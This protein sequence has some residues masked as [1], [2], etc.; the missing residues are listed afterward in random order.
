MPLFR[1]PDLCRGSRGGLVLG[2]I[3]QTSYGLRH[4]ECRSPAGRM[5]DGGVYAALCPGGVIEPPVTADCFGRK[6]SWGCQP[7][8]VIPQPSGIMFPPPTDVY[9]MIS[10]EA[11]KTIVF[12]VCCLSLRPQSDPRFY[13][14][15]P[16]NIPARYETKQIRYLLLLK[17]ICDIPLDHERI[18]PRKTNRG[19]DS[20]RLHLQC[21]HGKAGL[22]SD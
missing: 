20:V 4:P 13:Q 9:H 15:H 7:A 2:L 5:Y 22:H 1:D 10:N 18:H 11:V 12:A 8:R 3:H 17:M 16:A 21:F 6:T 14:K 19:E